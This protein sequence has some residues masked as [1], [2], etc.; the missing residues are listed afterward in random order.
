M[1]RMK[2]GNGLLRF[3]VVAALFAL[4]LTGCNGARKYEAVDLSSET[5]AGAEMS[6]N[7]ADL[8]AESTDTGASGSGDADV[9]ALGE[10]AGEPL[11]A[12]P[13]GGDVASESS[14]LAEAASESE[15]MSEAESVEAAREAAAAA[16]T[17]AASDDAETAPEIPFNG[18]TV[19]IDAGHQAKANTSKE[20]IGP[21]STT[22][23]AKMPEGAVGTSS[24]VP[25]YEVTLTVAKKLEKEL[26]NRGYHVVMIRTSHDVNMS[27]AER[28]V[29]ANKSGA[30][31]L[32]RLHAGSMDNSSV[33]GALST[34]MTAQNPYNASLHDKSYNLSKKIVDTVCGTTGTKNRGVQETDSSSDINWCEIPVCVFEMGFLSN[35]DEDTWLQDDG[36]QG[37][38]AS[39]IAGAVDAYFAEGN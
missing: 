19:A 35:P 16:Y 4:V 12:D 11:S 21:S 26:I 8:A 36:Y 18:H 34:C 10:A 9:Q 14:E 13:E 24:G 6:G 27:S 5:A 23:K 1:S 15:E 7:G 33:Y 3:L 28:S 32:I 2:K 25:E 37:K 31:I 20:P 22:M 38:I 29:A 30:D 17:A 39:G